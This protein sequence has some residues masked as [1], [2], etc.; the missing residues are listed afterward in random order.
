MSGAAT[1]RFRKLLEANVDRV[2][3]R[4]MSCLLTWAEICKILPVTDLNF[5][6][7]SSDQTKKIN[8]NSGSSKLRV[9]NETQTTNCLP[10]ELKFNPGFFKGQPNMVQHTSLE[11]EARLNYM[12]PP[13]P[14]QMGGQ[15]EKQRRPNGCEPYQGP[16]WCHPFMAQQT[17]IGGTNL[18][19]WATAGPS[20][21]ILPNEKNSAE[22]FHSDNESYE[23]SVREQPYKG[24]IASVI[25]TAELNYMDDTDPLEVKIQNGIRAVKRI[26]NE[27]D[28]NSLWELPSK[29]SKTYQ[30]DSAQLYNEE[31]DRPS[32]N[33]LRNQ[34]HPAKRKHGDNESVEGNSWDQPYKVQKTFLEDDPLNH[35]ECNRPSRLGL[36][37]ESHPTESNPDESH[38]EYNWNQ[39]FRTPNTS[40]ESDTRLYYRENAGPSLVRNR[41]KAIEYLPNEIDWDEDQPMENRNF[42]AATGTKPNNEGTAGPIQVGVRNVTPMN[43]NQ[44]TLVH[45]SINKVIVNIAVQGTGPKFLGNSHKTGWILFLCENLETL[46]WLKRE[47]PKLKPWPEARLSIMRENEFPKPISATILL[48]HIEGVTIA[49]A[50][51]LLSVQN[52]GLGTGQWRVLNSIDKKSGVIVFLAID[53]HSAEVLRLQN[54]KASLGT[55]TITFR[56]KYSSKKKKK[57]ASSAVNSN[58]WQRTATSTQVPSTKSGKDRPKKNKA[59]MYDVP[60]STP[61][62][63]RQEEPNFSCI[64]SSLK[65][66]MNGS[67]QE[68]GITLIPQTTQTLDRKSDENFMRN[69]EAKLLSNKWYSGVDNQEST[70]HNSPSDWLPW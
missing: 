12:E 7:N 59:I 50:L 68:H 2:K 54:F 70:P 24:N 13:H 14:S 61:N 48:P 6:Q 53:A 3:A 35:W 10:N 25:G 26:R 51:K 63:K 28:E 36:R 33:G 65:S 58:I 69:P 39:Y 1:R 18:N 47:V 20:Q 43:K 52:P 49:T 66:P 56:V 32:R 30:V 42:A 34:T 4:K 41:K 67:G 21:I 38:E 45:H 62:F 17:T 9:R 44:M 16:I 8:S 19:C 46:K 31:L 11:R 5:R 23:K 40:P 29:A 64:K 15:D 57:R 60:S 27:S 22:R 55:G 37:N